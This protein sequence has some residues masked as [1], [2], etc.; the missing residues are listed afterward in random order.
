M[1][2]ADLLTRPQR[3]HST[4]GDSGGPLHQRAST[5]YVQDKA[6]YEKVYALLDQITPILAESIGGHFF[7]PMPPRS[8]D[9]SSIM[10]SAKWDLSTVTYRLRVNATLE[11]P[12]IIERLLASAPC[13]IIRVAKL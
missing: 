1:G 10:V 9:D 11:C 5:S 8:T 13:S 2:K 3:T 6:K 4:I 12:M 7:P